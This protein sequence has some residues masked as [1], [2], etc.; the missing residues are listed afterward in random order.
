MA[1]R[2]LT[3]MLISA[4][5]NWPA[6]ALMKQGSPGNGVT[7]LIGAPVRVSIISLSVCTLRPTSN[8]FRLQGLPSCEGQQ[9]RGQLGGAVDGVRDRLDVALPPLLGE[10]RPPQQIDRGAD[11]R[12]QIVEI[13]RDAAGQ[14]SQRLEPLAVLERL[15]GLDPLR[16]LRNRA[17]ASAAMPAPGSETTAR[18][19]AE[20][21]IRCCRWWRA[22]ATG[23]PR[24]PVRR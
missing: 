12:E 9:L 1:S 19:R 11:H 17:A 6:S 10:M 23:S 21:K 22:S 2:A 24:F 18:W 4:V 13:V 20:P 15:L 5:S 14:L 3:A 7:I 16:R 8:T